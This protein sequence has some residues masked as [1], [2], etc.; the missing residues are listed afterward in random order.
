MSDTADTLAKAVELLSNTASALLK[1]CDSLLDQA[2]HEDL[3]AAVPKRLSEDASKR[4]SYA[5]QIPS[6]SVAAPIASTTSSA[7]L[8]GTE[9]GDGSL[10]RMIQHSVLYSLC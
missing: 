8:A 5:V 9:R 7:V 4:S 10:I 3:L 1:Q 6:Q 2:S